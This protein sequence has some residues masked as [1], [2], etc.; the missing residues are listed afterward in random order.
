MNQKEINLTKSVQNKN[1]YTEA[2]KKDYFLSKK[3]IREDIQPAERRIY[4]TRPIDGVASDNIIKEV[5]R[6]YQSPTTKEAASKIRGNKPRTS[7]HHEPRAIKRI[8]KLVVHSNVKGKIGV[9]RQACVMNHWVEHNKAMRIDK[10]NYL[11][12]EVASQIEA[13]EARQDNEQKVAMA[14]AAAARQMLGVSS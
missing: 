8:P 6:R 12:E 2:E 5:K 7:G 14:R 1:K 4:I 11:T 9:V 3:T 13:E 10:V